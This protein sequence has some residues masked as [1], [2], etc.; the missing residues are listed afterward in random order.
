M[1][2]AKHTIVI[3][4]EALQL[5][6][7]E[8]EKCKPEDNETVGSL[9][10]IQDQNLATI[11]YATPPGP[12]ACRSHA[13]VKTDPVYQNHCLNL[14]QNHYDKRG[15]CLLYQADWHHHPMP[16]PQLS[17][18]DL[19]QCFEILTDPDFS[20]LQGLPIILTTYQ[21]DA[22]VYLGFWVTLNR[23]YVNV[24]PAH[25]EVLSHEDPH[26]ENILRCNPY[27]SFSDLNNNSNSDSN[28]KYR[29]TGQCVTLER[30]SQEIKA[31]RSV[32]T[33]GYG[34]RR[35][36][37]GLHCLWAKIDDAVFYAV[38]P[39]EFPLNPPACFLVS[40]AVV[41]EVIPRLTWNSCARIG[42]IVEEIINKGEGNEEKSCSSEIIDR[43]HHGAVIHDT[44]SLRI[45]C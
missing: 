5:I 33:T 19:D 25:V 34:F 1:K 38:L 24:M 21:R 12:N 44:R 10:G 45:L 42:D 37:G 28:D 14:L 8:S 11:L 30:L 29:A 6:L 20:Y 18:Q 39:P 16:F 23:G 3:V 22:L 31:L 43:W 13:R 35:T 26:I 36:P 2:N 9:I 7:S 41:K 27:I 40:S 32:V 17:Q 15:V 4:R